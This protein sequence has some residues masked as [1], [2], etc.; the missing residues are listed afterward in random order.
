MQNF[1]FNLLCMHGD[2]GKGQTLVIGAG[3]D[4]A[5]QVNFISL[6]FGGTLKGSILGGLKFKTDLPFIIDKC[7][8]KVNLNYIAY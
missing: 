3:N 1:R 7:K 4:Q 8:N 6:L 2:Q 5:I